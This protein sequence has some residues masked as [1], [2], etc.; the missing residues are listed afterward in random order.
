MLQMQSR[1]LDQIKY[2]RDLARSH[3][4]QLNEQLKLMQNEKED[5]ENRLNGLLI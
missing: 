3:S 1:T 2:E 5:I 4:H